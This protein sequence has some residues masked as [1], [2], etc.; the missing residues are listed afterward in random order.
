ML[1]VQAYDNFS[2]ILLAYENFDYEKYLS[3]VST[4][5]IEL[6]LKKEHL[7]QY[8]FLNLL[9]P[10]AFSY[11][12]EMAEISK[13]H[14]LRHFGKVI[15]LY[16]PIY[17]SNYCSSD[18]SYCGFSKKN[19]IV[20][21][22][23]SEEDL[24]KEAIEIA[25]SGIK[26]ILVLTGEASKKADMKYL[27]MAVSVLKKYFTSIS[28]E[29]YPL[30]THEYKELKDLGVDGLTIYQEVYDKKI[31]KEVHTSGE[32]TNYT[33]RLDAPQ[34]GADAGIRAL[35]VGCLF[36]LGNIY[37]EAFLSA[38]HAKYLMEK[39]FDAEIS[40]S[41]PRINNAA[42]DFTPK[43][44]ISDKTYVQFML[45]YRLYMP[46]IGMNVSTREEAKFRDNLIDIAATK[47]SAGSKTDVGGYT[48]VDKSTAQFE[49][50]DERSVEEISSMIRAR[51][52][53][54][55]FKDWEIIR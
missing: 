34:R 11:I 24:E 31:Y 36:G 12:E 33:Y 2:D 37:S 27:K 28:I 42:G 51:G 7:N 20:R 23:L 18:C 17:I 52:Y 49:I 43:F 21:K 8:D 22:H 55:I 29:V 9:S 26:H 3:K 19:R 1:N 4:K 38:L 44:N 16:L 32:K 6:S 47:F 14:K 45:A 41:M 13:K 50:S 39:Y 46:N 5:D 25:K 35:N 15:Q 40:I 53:Q 10:K 30:E 54:P 48:D